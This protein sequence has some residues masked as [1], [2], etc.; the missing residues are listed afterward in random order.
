MFGTPLL[1][2]F[3]LIAPLT[4]K[5]PRGQERKDRERPEVEVD[6]ESVGVVNETIMWRE[7]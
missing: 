4:P 7:G 2:A 6:V 3:L 1:P 5:K